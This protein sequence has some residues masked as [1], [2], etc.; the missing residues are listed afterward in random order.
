MTARDD[1]ARPA[2]RVKRAIDIVSSGLG[3]VVL[4]PVMGAVA[5]VVAATLGRPVLFRQMRPGRHGRPFQLVKFRT[6]R[7]GGPQA[8]PSDDARR[9]TPATRWLRSTSLDELPTL[10]NVLRGD[11][12]LVGPRPLLMEYLDRYTPEQARRHEVRPGITGL[13]QVRGRN[14][15]RWSEK[16]AYDVWYVDHRSLRLD[17]AIL[18]QTAVAVL[19]RDGIA[20]EHCVT[21][22]EFRP[23]RA[24]EVV[25]R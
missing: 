6:M 4:A 22:P 13:A 19:R 16:F 11:M 1:G 23:G 18:L 3:L 17:L 20:A 25:R 9:L 5:V 8:G 14:R 15:L 24:G 21:A 7:P 10:W 12:S 2:D